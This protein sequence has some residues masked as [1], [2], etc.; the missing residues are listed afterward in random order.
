M[1]ENG[2]FITPYSLKAS[3]K[4]IY[5]N[6]PETSPQYQISTANKLLLAQSLRECQ[7]EPIS[8]TAYPKTTIVASC[9]CENLKAIWDEVKASC[10]PD[11]SNQFCTCP[12]GS[13]FPAGC[14][15]V[16]GLSPCATCCDQNQIRQM[17]QGWASSCD[18]RVICK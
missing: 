12:A 6:I 11:I 10:T 13:S 15:P 3:A 2:G 9:T 14:S 5:I 7:I 8:E 17:V 4:T 16:C 18:T 1:E